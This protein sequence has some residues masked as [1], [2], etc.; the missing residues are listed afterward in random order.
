MLGIPS[1]PRAPS[2][3][4]DDFGETTENEIVALLS[5]HVDARER[6][7]EIEVPPGTL[8]SGHLTVP[9]AP[10]LGGGLARGRLAP[11]VGCAVPR[12]ARGRAEQGW[13]CD[14]AA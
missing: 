12:I 10:T 2:F 1:A 7:V 9:G 13:T 4:Y 5:E 11:P 8:L 3:W 14:P 6:E